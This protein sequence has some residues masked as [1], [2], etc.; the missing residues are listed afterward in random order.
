MKFAPPL[1]TV[2]LLA[3]GMTWAD[4]PPAGQGP[5]AACKA[6][7]EKWCSGIEPGGGR[8]VACLRQNDAQLSAP[9]KEAL[10]KARARKPPDAPA[11]R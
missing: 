2:L 4:D 1:L 7:V 11:S 8:I 6:D 9:C 3:S 5:R 10:A